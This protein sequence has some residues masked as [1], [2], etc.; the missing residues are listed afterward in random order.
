LPAARSSASVAI[1]RSSHGAC[2]AAK[3]KGSP[4]SA[5]QKREWSDPRYRADQA[6]RAVDT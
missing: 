3:G 5:R 4:L 6:R 2:K 1:L